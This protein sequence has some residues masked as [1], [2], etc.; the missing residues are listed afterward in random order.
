VR[1]ASVFRFF[2]GINGVIWRTLIQK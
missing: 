2:R 1:G